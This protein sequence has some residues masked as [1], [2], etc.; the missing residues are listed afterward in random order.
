M[1]IRNTNIVAVDVAFAIVVVV[2][3][4]VIVQILF[5]KSKAK[6]IDFTI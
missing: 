5:V 4:V 6:C 3:A 2:A 1:S